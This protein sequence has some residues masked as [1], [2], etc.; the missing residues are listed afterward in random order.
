[1]EARRLVV[2]A[3][4]ALCASALP[5][6]VAARDE[7]NPYPVGRCGATDREIVIFCYVPNRPSGVYADATDRHVLAV[8]GDDLTT[9]RPASLGPEDVI[10]EDTGANARVYLRLTPAER[11]ADDPYDSDLPF[12]TVWQESNNAPGLQTA[13]VRCGQFIWFA[14]CDSWMGPYNIALLN[15]DTLVA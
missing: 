7:C 3:L 1:M 11:F 12:S 6:P 5:Q 9:P 10:A 13:R 2:F 8:A 15:A 14:E 4:V